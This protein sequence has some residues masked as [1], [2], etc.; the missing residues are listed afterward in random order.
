MCIMDFICPV[1][2]CTF[3]DFMVCTAHVN[4]VVL[5]NVAVMSLL[6]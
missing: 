2:C 4:F 5:C 1:L 6:K 3:L